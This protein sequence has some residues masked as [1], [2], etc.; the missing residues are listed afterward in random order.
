MHKIIIP[1]SEDTKWPMS[2]TDIL[3]YDDSTGLYYTT[4]KERILAEQDKKIEELEKR[5]VAHIKENDEKVA[6]KIK[7]LE[8][9]K[10]QLTANYNEFI[11]QYKVNNARMIEMIEKLMAKE[12]K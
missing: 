8:N 4:T 1:I 7:E 9:L 5:V 10:V 3:L 11:M 12:E 6:Q 2:N